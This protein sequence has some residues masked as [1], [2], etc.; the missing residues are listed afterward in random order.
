MGK[1]PVAIVGGGISGLSAAY[2]LAKAGVP[3]TLIEKRPRLRGASSSRTDRRLPRRRRSR[4]LS[5]C[6]ALGARTD[7]GPGNGRRGHRLERPSPQDLH[8]QRW[9]HGR[10]AGRP[11][12]AGSNEDRPDPDHAAPEVRSTKARMGLEW[13]RRPPSAPR[14]DCTVAAFVA[15]NYGGGRCLAEPLLAG[16]YGGSR[17][18]SAS[19]AC[20]RVWSRSRRS[21]AACRRASWPDGSRLRRPLSRCSK[22]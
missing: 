20:C 16:V 2:Y 13:F 22:R 12:D 1:T 10:D 14:P 4:Q 9:P 3:S 5:R 18:R 11:A 21:T 15:E 17:N 7:P 6:Q 8:P 19:R